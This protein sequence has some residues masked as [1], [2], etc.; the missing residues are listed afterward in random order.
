VSTLVLLGPSLA[1]PQE[2]SSDVVVTTEP[3]PDAKEIGEIVAKLYA[4]ASKAAKAKDIILPEMTPELGRLATDA[5]LGLLSRFDV[6]QTLSL[7]L[8]REGLDIQ[9][10]WKRKIAR[11]KL[12]SGAE[13][14]TDCPDFSALAGCQQIKGF[15]KSYIEGRRPPGC[16]LF[17][18]EIE[19]ML[20]G[21]GTD[22]SGV[23]GKMLG[24]FL[25]WTQDRKVDGLLLLGVPGAGK[26]ATAKCTAGAAKAPCFRL[27]FAEAQGS[28][29]GE[30]EKNLKSALA[31]VDAISGGKVLM[32]ATC[33]SLDSLAP[34][35]MG[36]FRLGTFFYDYPSPEENAALWD[37]YLKRFGLPAETVLPPS[38]NWVGREIESA[39][40]QAWL[41]NKPVKE[42]TQYIVPQCISQKAK[43]EEL[44][45]K[46]SGRFLSASF[47]GVY[48]VEQKASPFQSGRNLEIN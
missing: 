14:W 47:P 28:L 5:A 23:T 46:V 18:D 19:K 7:A 9:E 4:A 13:I 41:F 6:E 3:A 15:L 1:L 17:L 31:S 34:E 30:S 44:R 39:C 2:I 8:G 40:Y 33:N 25:T 26:S 42:V 45:N 36:R 22:S 43:L 16:I 12:Q 21:A 27:S 37:M 10:I 29:V 24:Q 35:L 20:A 11:V 32:I 38:S 48:S